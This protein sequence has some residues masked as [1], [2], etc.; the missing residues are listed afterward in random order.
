M[1][2]LASHSGTPGGFG[3]AAVHAYTV[4]FTAG[5]VIFAVGLLLALTLLPSRHAIRARTAASGT[6]LPG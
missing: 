2:Y 3:N 4:G 1:G 5:G 6:K